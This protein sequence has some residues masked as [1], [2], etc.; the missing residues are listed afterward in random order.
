MELLKKSP[1]SGQVASTVDLSLALGDTTTLVRHLIQIFYQMHEVE[2][3]KLII[4]LY[5]SVHM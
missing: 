2:R 1:Y 5:N 4:M 3:D